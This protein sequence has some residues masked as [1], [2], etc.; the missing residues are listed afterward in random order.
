MASLMDGAKVTSV[1]ELMK[2]F[3]LKEDQQQAEKN[4]ANNGQTSGGP[5]VHLVKIL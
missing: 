3:A 5:H 2:Q 4:G 1:S